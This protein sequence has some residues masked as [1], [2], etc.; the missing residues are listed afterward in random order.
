[1]GLTVTPYGK[2]QAGVGFAVAVDDLINIVPSL[3][4][5]HQIS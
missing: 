1:M 4:T 3:I 5:L 2:G